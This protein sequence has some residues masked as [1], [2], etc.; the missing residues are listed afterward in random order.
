ML[1]LKRYLK[2][3]NLP[4]ATRQPKRT[5]QEGFEMR[6]AD[7][8]KEL[9]ARNAKSIFAKLIAENDEEFTLH[10]QV[11][12]WRMVN[13]QEQGLRRTIIEKPLSDS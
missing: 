1:S 5:L 11:K 12:K 7:L 6:T 8:I 9:T 2:V 3:R 4:C 13:S 10:L